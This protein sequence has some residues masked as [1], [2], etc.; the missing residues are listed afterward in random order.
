M[1]SA[2]PDREDPIFCLSLD[3]PSALDL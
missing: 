2:L 3:K 1:H